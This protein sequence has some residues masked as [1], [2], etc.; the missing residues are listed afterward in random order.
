MILSAP[1]PRS[2]ITAMPRLALLLATL[3]ALPACQGSDPQPL[4]LISRDPF[5]GDGGVIGGGGASSMVGYTVPSGGFNTTMIRL[6]RHD[7]ANPDQLTFVGDVAL[8][9][10]VEVTRVVVT[11]QVS[12]VVAGGEVSLVDLSVPSLPVDVLSF[13]RGVEGVAVEGRWLLAISG[14]DLAL[15]NRD[16][17]L[18]ITTYTSSVAPTGILATQGMF[19]VFTTT[20]YVTVDPS[21]PT[22]TFQPVADPDLRNIRD[23]YADGAGAV[24]A[25]PGAAVA[26]SKVLRLDLTAPASPVVVWRHDVPGSYVTFAWDGASTSVVAVHGDGDGFP[27]SFREGFLVREADDGVH[28]TGIPLPL[29]FGGG[30]PL[31][32]HASRLFAMDESGM[33]LL[34]FR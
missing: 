29:W 22:P 24:V 27:G 25:G 5:Y 21:G 8:E 1:V 16:A 11:D 26:Q 32:A 17:P 34:G 2:R 30:H 28:D 3:A 20:G 9:P 15:V 19:L 10:G 13:A 7:A 33:L 12:A 23:A 6:V 4:Q 18:S 31:A 14:N